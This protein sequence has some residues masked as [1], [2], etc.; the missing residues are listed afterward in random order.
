MTKMEMY[1]KSGLGFQQL[2]TQ[3]LFSGQV[4]GCLGITMS[5]IVPGLAV[6]PWQAGTRLYSLHSVC[7]LIDRTPQS[8]L[9][10]LSVLLTLFLGGSNTDPALS[11]LIV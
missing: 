4:M 2:V 5:V 10:G 8:A 1:P 3:L 6:L 9:Q 7:Q 11:S